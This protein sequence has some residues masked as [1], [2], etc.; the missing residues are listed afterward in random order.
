MGQASFFQE[1][2]KEFLGVGKDL[3][4]K[5]IKD[6]PEEENNE[7]IEQNTENENLEEE[8]AAT[9]DIDS[10]DMNEIPRSTFSANFSQEV[11]VLQCL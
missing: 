3:Q 8:L 6:V 1:R 10:A 9:S 11:S 5:E 2:M 7:C 4:I